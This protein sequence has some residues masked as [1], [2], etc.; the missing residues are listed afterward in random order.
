MPGLPS[1][2]PRRKRSLLLT[3]PSR[4]RLKWAKF[5]I[6][7]SLALTK[8][9]TLSR[10]QL[11]RLEV[12]FVTDP[13]FRLRTS[14]LFGE[15]MRQHARQTHTELVRF[16]PHASSTDSGGRSAELLSLN[17]LARPYS[18][19]L[20]L[21]RS[22]SSLSVSQ[23]LLPRSLSRSP[24]LLS[25][26]TPRRLLNLRDSVV[27]KNAQHILNAARIFSAA[28]VTKSA[29]TERPSRQPDPTATSGRKTLPLKVVSR[30]TSRNPCPS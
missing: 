26:I 7:S 15:T 30:I 18:H 14:A 4:S 8:S 21:Q 11:P 20:R 29:W 17:L 22:P 23:S 27:G 3:L 2:E 1:L 16:L 6:K 25:I 5:S 12:K 9:L 13:R 28:L 19:A 10:Q 24:S